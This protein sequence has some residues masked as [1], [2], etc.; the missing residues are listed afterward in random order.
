[1]Y[2]GGNHHNA[3]T[4]L[5]YDTRLGFWDREMESRELARLKMDLPC[6]PSAQSVES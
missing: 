3:G 4:Y 1:M 2:M 6:S 5:D